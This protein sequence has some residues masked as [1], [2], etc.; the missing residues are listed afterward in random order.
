M[1]SKLDDYQ[2]LCVLGRGAYGMCKKVQRKADKKIFAW[3]EVEYGHFPEYNKQQLNTEVNLLR[4]LKHPNIVRFYDRI[5]DSP[6]SKLYLVME[7][8]EGGDLARLIEKHSKPSCYMDEDFILRVFAQLTSALKECHKRT[9]GGTTVLHRDL[10]PANIFLDAKQ[11]VKLGDFGLARILRHDSSF[12]K[13][14]VGTPCYMSPEQ[15]SSEHYDEKSD[16]WSLGVVVY[17]L[18]ALARPF[19]ASN[20]VALSELIKQGH[21]LPIPNIFSTELHRIIGRMLNLKAYERP[22]VH[23]LLKN[24]LLSRWTSTERRLI[25][26]ETK[27]ICT[28]HGYGPCPATNPLPRKAA[29]TVS[30][31]PLPAQPV[32]R[33]PAY[34]FPRLTS[35]LR[36]TPTKKHCCCGTHRCYGTHR[37]CTHSPRVGCVKY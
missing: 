12:A 20:V 16:I 15:M 18:C 29:M 19:N 33:R 36:Y 3:K 25:P 27:P 7:Y 28:V 26:E 37:C 2:E 6:N 10:K 24:S 4:E 35:D 17:E 8:C 34:E 22:S 13:S 11:N 30:R 21:Y 1:A 9:F 5:Y 31:V 14:F 32:A 23:D